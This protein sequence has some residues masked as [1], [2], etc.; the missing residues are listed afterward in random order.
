MRVTYGQILVLIKSGAFKVLSN[1][2]AKSFSSAENYL[3]F[4]ESIETQARKYNS[5]ISKLDDSIE[6]EELINN[7]VEITDSP[8]SRETLETCNDEFSANIIIGIRPFLSEKE[9]G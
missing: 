3:E 1:I 9:I 4:L 5:L 6:I 8:F 2:K 7:E